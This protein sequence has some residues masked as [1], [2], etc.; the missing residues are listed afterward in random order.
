MQLIHKNIHK[1][2]ATFTKFT[3]YNHTKICLQ[4][5]ICKHLYFLKKFAFL[6]KIIWMSEKSYLYLYTQKF[7]LVNIM[8]DRIQKILDEENISAS[9][10]A[11]VLGV[12]R[13]SI[14]HILSGRNKPSLDFVQRILQKFPEINSDWL[15]FGKGDIYRK[16]NDTP[17]EP[18]KQA[19]T[20]PQQVLEP[21]SKP[22]EVKDTAITPQ[23][24]AKEVNSQGTQSI[25]TGNQMQFQ[26]P[27]PDYS[28]PLSQPQRIEQPEYQAVQQPMQNGYQQPV[29]GY[30][31]PTQGY[32]QPSQGYQQPMYQPEYQG[33]QQPQQKAVPID[34]L[35][36][37]PDRIIVFYS[38]NTFAWY[39][40]M[41]Q[42]QAH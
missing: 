11:D 41:Q 28:R 3:F 21:V 36:T 8:K 20:P 23:R 37:N 30:Q 7:K 27:Q 17:E 14:S 9:K 15:L 22:V 19:S 10:F 2:T 40:P 26:Q 42:A 6:S 25:P 38:N 39:S 18:K 31:R 33:V 35:Q 32:Q 4:S 1:Y 16:Q 12:Q 24:Q 13:S 5:Y 34:I 29:Q